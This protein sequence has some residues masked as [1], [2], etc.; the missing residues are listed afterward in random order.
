[1]RLALALLYLASLYE[2]LDECVNNIV[3][4]VG[5]YDVGTYL[6]TCFL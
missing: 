3:R 2:R 4:L 1:M 5:R 6:D